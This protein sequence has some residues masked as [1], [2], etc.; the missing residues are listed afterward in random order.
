MTGPHSH[1]LPEPN[2]RT[3]EPASQRARPTGTAVICCYTERRW[4]LLLASVTSV[5]AQRN[6][7]RALVVVDHN[8]GLLARLRAALPDVE[9]LPSEGAPGLSGA[10]NTGVTH[11]DTEV[12]LFLDDDAVAAPDWAGTLL[13]CFADP[14]VAAAGGRVDPDWAGGHPPGWFPAE[15]GWVVGCSYTG[16]PVTRAPVRNPIGASMAVRR[17]AFA[18]AGGFSDA[19]G[20]VGT[21]PVGCEETELCIRIAHRDPD[22]L[23][24]LDPAAG[25]LHHVPAERQRVRY[26][27]RRCY[28]EGR[29]KSAVARLSGAAGPGAG[30]DSLRTE[31]DY[32][33]KVL[34]R[35]LV[36]HAG[37]GLRGSAADLAA[38]GVLVAGLA[39]AVLGFTVQ[40]VRDRRRPG[41]LPAPD[42][43]PSEVAR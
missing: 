10:R 42:A 35:A 36:R 6:R 38:A 4:D 7:V 22:A 37:R 3:G 32:A 16:Q 23:V 5:T 26:L 8:D 25:V 39:A 34:P 11:S 28:H 41:A 18:R 13:D 20:R 21:L 14:R 12:V 24:L 9:V 1:L 17:S 29:S 33:R 19:L 2:G 15:F 30:A 31:A 40:T 27:V 43:E